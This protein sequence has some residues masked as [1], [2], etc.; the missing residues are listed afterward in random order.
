MSDRRKQ[1]L[2]GLRSI[3]TVNMAGYK[4][5]PMTSSESSSFCIMSSFF[6]GGGANL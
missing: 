6:W 3:Y 1:E 5:A 2:G 4:S